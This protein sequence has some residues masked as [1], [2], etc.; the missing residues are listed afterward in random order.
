MIAFGPIPSRRLGLSLGINNIVSH[1]VCSYNCVYCQIGD[2]GK[3]L[4]KRDVFYEPGKMLEAIE[5]HLNKLDKE[6]IPDYLTFVANGEP[7]LDINLGKEI[8]LLKKFNIPV[9]VI[10]NAS[11]MDDPE[12][13][14]DLMKADWV[15]VK[16]D[17]VSEDIWKKINR[18]LDGI[19]LNNI[20]HGIIVFA[21]EYNGKLHTETMLIK[22]LNDAPE[23]MKDTASFIGLLKPKKAYLSI[24]TRPPAVKEVKPIP[25][26]RIAEAW[27]IYQQEGIKTELLTGFE[28]TNT[29]FTGNVFEDI[30]NIAAVHPLREDTM[31]E[32]LKQDKADE[33]VVKSLIK[34]GLIK[35]STYNGKTY[36]IRK[37]HF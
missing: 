3:R 16:V 26:E 19:G 15:S 28:G 4:L 25:E 17:T 20:L 21:A 9:A 37:Y 11:H 27:Q 6:H 18:P 34:Q 14:K 32:L 36:Y 10:S 8:Q 13:R 33:S 35:K 22:G 1:K 7:T 30:L 2:T 23:V 5:S 31:A 24:P 12:V 29:G